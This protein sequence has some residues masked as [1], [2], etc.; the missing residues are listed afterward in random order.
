MESKEVSSSTQDGPTT[1][2]EQAID[3]LNQLQQAVDENEEAHVEQ[4]QQT[5][6]TTTTDD[7]T[8]VAAA[9]TTSED[10]SQD[11]FSQ[12]SFNFDSQRLTIANALNEIYMNSLPIHYKDWAFPP[13][14]QMLKTFNQMKILNL[15]QFMQFCFERQNE[16]KEKLCALKFIYDGDEQRNLAN[17]LAPNGQTLYAKQN[18]ALFR[19]KKIASVN[20]LLFELTQLILVRPV[21]TASDMKKHMA[22]KQRKLSFGCPRLDKLTGGGIRTKCITELWGEAGSCKSQMCM[23]LLTMAVCPTCVGGMSGAAVYLQTESRF[24]VDRFEEFLRERYDA[25]MLEKSVQEQKGSVDKDLEALEDISDLTD[26]VQ[27]TKVDS[28]ED[29]IK[30][31]DNEVGTYCNRREDMTRQVKLIII[32]SIASLFRTEKATT[33]SAQLGAI[34]NKLRQYADRYNLAVFIVNQVTDDFRNDNAPAFQQLSTQ[35]PA[36]KVDSQMVYEAV[37]YSNPELVEGND[38]Q[39]ELLRRFRRQYYMSLNPKIRKKPALGLAWSCYVNMSL[40]TSKSEKASTVTFKKSS[41]IKRSRSQYN[42]KQPRNSETREEQEADIQLTQEVVLRQLHVVFAPHV[43]N[44][45]QSFILEKNGI[46]GVDVL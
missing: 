24:S 28:V 16:L 8:I 21:I 29:L 35:Q 9:E 45:T 3:L 23:Q 10:L 42:G 41:S 5:E 4:H 6:E 40:M 44:G 31:I 30:V 17:E 14:D 26:A 32:D 38:E 39:D 11:F 20:Y 19:E 18:T 34:A 1:T 27:Q 33:R 25:A 46:R 7:T 43:K 2:Q 36:S 22:R 12:A 37:L 15:Q 13:L